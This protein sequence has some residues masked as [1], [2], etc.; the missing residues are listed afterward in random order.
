MSALFCEAAEP[1]EARVLRVEPLEY[2]LACRKLALPALWQPQQHHSG[3]PLVDPV[4][5]VALV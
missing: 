2:Q 4:K 1:V 3:R 5:R